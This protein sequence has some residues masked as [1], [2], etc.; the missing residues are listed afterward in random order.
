MK[1]ND[2]TI[3]SIDEVKASDKF[4]VLLWLKI[5]STHNSVLNTRT[6]PQKNKKSYVKTPL[7]TS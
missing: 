2:L 4:S 5:I 1:D 7:W 3:F 6:L